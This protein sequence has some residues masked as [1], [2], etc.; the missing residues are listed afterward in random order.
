MNGLVQIGIRLAAPLLSK[1]RKTPEEGCYTSVF[2]AVDPSLKDKGGLYL[3]HCRPT[4]AGTAALD[5]EMAGK[6]WALSEKLT[7][8][9]H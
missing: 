5:V 1:L 7:G 6:L 8:L 4:R 2:A 3:L 9:A